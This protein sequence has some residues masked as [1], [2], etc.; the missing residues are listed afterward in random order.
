MDRIWPAHCRPRQSSRSEI[1]SWFCHLDCKRWGAK[2][3]K[4]IVKIPFYRNIQFV[5]CLKLFILQILDFP[6]VCICFGNKFE[7][8]QRK[9]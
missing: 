7:F 8:S 1:S 3:K 6:F 5:S 2:L 9:K 4:I